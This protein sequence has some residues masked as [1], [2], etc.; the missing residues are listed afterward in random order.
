MIRL[1][2]FTLKDENT[3]DG[4]IGIEYI[5]LRPGEKLY[6]ELLIG[7]NA[8]GTSH[9]RIMRAEEDAYSWDEIQSYL[10]LLEQSINE[11]DSKKVSKLLME[12]V[13]GYKRN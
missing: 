13:K 9:P 11:L 3:P 12:V 7:D 2:G 8:T 6:E 4:D 5:G 1:M 10:I